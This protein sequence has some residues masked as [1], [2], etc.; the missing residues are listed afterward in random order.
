MMYQE[1]ISLFFCIYDTDRGC[2]T[3]L[4]K[5]VMQMPYHTPF[6]ADMDILYILNGDPYL[7]CKARYK[8]I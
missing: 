5:G 6:T 4:P 2:R 1:M 3:T 8:F 7:L